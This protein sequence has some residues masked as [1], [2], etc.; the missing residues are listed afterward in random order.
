MEQQRNWVRMT[1]GPALLG[2]ACLA[3]SLPLAA[4]TTP[5]APAKPSV[6]TPAATPPATTPAPATT[7]KAGE[8]DAIEFDKLDKNKDG[9]LDKTEAMMEPRVLAEWT[10]V[11]TNKD[12]KVSKDEFL[13]FERAR[14]AKK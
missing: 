10:K 13:T 4:Q 14:H 2:A 6:T 9:Y 5:A 8:D 7:R 1:F 3:V 11:D 12:G